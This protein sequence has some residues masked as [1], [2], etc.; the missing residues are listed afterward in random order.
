MKIQHYSF[1]EIM[2]NG[3]RRDHDVMIFGDNLTDWIRD[4]GHKVKLIDLKELVDKKPQIIV[5]GKG[6]EGKLEVAEEALDELDSLGIEV[7]SYKTP[8]SV[9]AYND[10]VESGKKVAALLHLTC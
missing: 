10:L 5:F 4:E 2:V 1:G 9:D 3:I 7:F 8:E 6:S